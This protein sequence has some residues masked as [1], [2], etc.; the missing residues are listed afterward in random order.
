MHANTK[1]E[2]VFN[3]LGD[4]FCLTV[5]IYTPLFLNPLKSLSS[6]L[7]LYWYVPRLKNHCI[8]YTS[9]KAKK[10]WVLVFKSRFQFTVI[11]YILGKQFIVYIAQK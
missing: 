6:Y 4:L 5:F 11:T 10:R 7:S 3:N 1:G 9:P 2:A 8:I